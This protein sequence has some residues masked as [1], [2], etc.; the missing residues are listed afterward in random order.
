M[1][2]VHHGARATNADGPWLTMNFSPV[3]DRAAFGFDLFSPSTTTDRAV[4]G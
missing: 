2:M 1:I 4:G 3:V